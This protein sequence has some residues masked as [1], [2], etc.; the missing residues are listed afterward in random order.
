MTV[1]KFCEFLGG[2][3][4]T[5]VSMIFLIVAAIIKFQNI[6]FPYD[7][8][9]VTIII[10]G[11]PIV[12]SGLKSLFIKGKMTASLLITIAMCAAVITGETFAAAEVAFIM[13]L[14][15]IL[16]DL[17]INKAK[18]GIKKLLKIAP[19]YA[20][21]ITD[22]K[23]EILDVKE[24]KKGDI[25]RVLAGE[26]IPFDGVIIS[27]E[28]AVKQAVITGESTPV[29]KQ[30]GDIV[31]SGTTNC[32]GVIDIKVE[33][34]FIENTIQ[35]L[36]QLV[37]QA[38]KNKAQ[39]ERTIDKI[40]SVLIPLAIFLAIGIYCETGEILR[41]V[42]ILVVFC[43]CS[44]VLSTPTAIIAGI[45]NG[46]RNGII[47]KTGEALE[48][49][50]KCNIFAF[51]KTGTLT[52][53]ELEVTDIETLSDIS[54]DELLYLASSSENKSEHPIGKAIVK[55]ALSK[56][57][58]L[59]Q[60]TD[61]KMYLGKGVYAKLDNKK[62]HI[63]NEKFM[64][65]IDIEL[66]DDFKTTL[67]KKR[68]DGKIT[69]VIAVDKIP[70]G[71]ISLSD[72]LRETSKEAIDK[73]S[74]NAKTILLTGDN[75]I[76]AEYFAKKAGIK[77][78]VSNLLPRQKAEYITDLQRNGNKVCMIGDGVND[79]AALKVSD[80][81]IA[82]EGI[83]SDIALESSDI[84]IAGSDLNKIVY[85]KNL[86]KEVLKTIKFNIS[87]S[88]IMNIFAL[89]IAAM[90]LIT[91]DIGAIIHNA[92]SLFVISNA[93]LLYNDKKIC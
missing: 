29:D 18:K 19:D 71:I 39:T 60:T 56:N 53:G 24:I 15:E 27:G 79:A 55:Y 57:Y 69:L 82:L 54:N 63:G 40:A 67:N 45:G 51:D 49:I 90:G 89:I 48:N 13:S 62:I 87:I 76:T 12:Y 65:D 21:K 92:V 25:I 81:G 59:G 23:E 42:T 46:T 7:L 41:A 68:P 85:L 4:M 88:I 8:S 86:S 36:I 30:E 50:G 47:V 26:N 52:K 70:K 37:K 93:A 91:P 58:V 33:K 17:T 61:F 78:T 1:E 9:K 66:S 6:D 77:E 34:E 84:I 74:K 44:L 35:K 32:F 22:N 14:G 38:E 80:V 31:F 75:P 2:I 72:T 11:I 16:E 20:R 28:T 43:P 73:I 5:I 10:S 83:S 3:K 64:N